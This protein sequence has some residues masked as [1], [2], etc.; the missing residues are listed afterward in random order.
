M[1]KRG[2]DSMPVFTREGASW[3]K[4]NKIFGD[5]P[6]NLIREINTAIAAWYLLIFHINFDVDFL[7]H[8]L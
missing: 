2:V 8:S 3:G 1:E 4:L 7:C 5:D 6:E